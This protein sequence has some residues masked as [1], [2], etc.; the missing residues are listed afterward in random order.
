MIYD[1][2]DLEST[3]CSLSVKYLKTPLSCSLL[4]SLSFTALLTS[5]DM[6]SHEISHTE[7]ILTWKALAEW[8]WIKDASQ[9]ASKNPVI[10]MHE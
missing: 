1:V 6:V 2:F 8:T 4:L 10:D 3:N 5:R 7:L 9:E